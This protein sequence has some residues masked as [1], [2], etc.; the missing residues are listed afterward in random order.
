M[1]KPYKVVLFRLAEVNPDTMMVPPSPAP[2]PVT[3]EVSAPGGAV[4]LAGVSG[5]PVVATTGVPVVN[6]KPVGKVTFILATVVGVVF[7]L[8]VTIRSLA[9]LPLIL[10]RPR[11]KPACVKLLALATAGSNN[12]AAMTTVTNEKTMYFDLDIRAIITAMRLPKLALVS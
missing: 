5:K 10:S 3:A 1:M 2:A 4:I 6:V 7:N 11:R 8:K 12:V 9:V